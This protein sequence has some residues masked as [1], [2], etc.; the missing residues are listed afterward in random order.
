MGIKMHHK[1]NTHCFAHLIFDDKKHSM[2]HYDADEWEEC[3]IYFALY[4]YTFEWMMKEKKTTNKNQ[5][6]NDLVVSHNCT[7]CTEPIARYCDSLLF[8]CCVWAVVAW[9]SLLF[10][11]IF[12]GGKLESWR[13]CVERLLRVVRYRGYDVIFNCCMMTKWL[14]YRLTGWRAR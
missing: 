9:M 1:H 2:L 10:L 11:F 3:L 5:D 7:D 12:F 13:W 8:K 14:A 4:V 6:K